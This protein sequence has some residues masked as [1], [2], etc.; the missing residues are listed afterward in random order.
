MA[1]QHYFFKL[2]APRPTFPH[3]ITAEETRLMNEHGLYFQQQFE[4]GKLLLYGPVLAAGGAFGLGILEVDSE[5]EARLFG[6]G[7]HR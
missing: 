6:E 4:A 1:K 7:A 2:V 3:D 5:Q